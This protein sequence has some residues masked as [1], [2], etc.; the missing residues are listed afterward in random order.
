LP[1]LPLIED[2]TSRPIPAGSNI[3]AEYDPA[4]QWYNA[5]ITISAGWL[6]T[7]GKVDYDT[8]SQ[9]PDDIRAQ[10]RRVGVKPDVI[11]REEKLT[12][13]DWYTATLGQKSKEKHSHES[14]RI[15]EL[16]I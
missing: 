13:T 2:L 9:S 7:G 11:E 3:L 6:S 12:I 5:S 1:R 8:F 16:S 15:P 14:L 4:S 10:F